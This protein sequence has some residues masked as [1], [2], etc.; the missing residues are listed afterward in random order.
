MLPEG[1]QL[2]RQNQTDRAGEGWPVEPEGDKEVRGSRPLA[3]LGHF[4]RACSSSP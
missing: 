4:H 2:R 1:F 3:P